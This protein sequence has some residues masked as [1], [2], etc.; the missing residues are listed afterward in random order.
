M[1]YLKVIP[2]VI[3]ILFLNALLASEKRELNVLLITA[4]TLR[5]DRVSFHV[6]D[7]VKTPHLDNLAEGSLVFTR[8]F[9]H[10]PVT[11][12]SHVNIITGTTPLYHGISDNPGFVLEERF[13]T[14]A[15]HL[16]R[17]KYK[18]GAFIA[19]FPLDSRFGLDQG[20]DH[21]DDNYG[22]QN[23]YQMF[24][25]ER[26]ADEVVDPALTWIK[27]QDGKWFCW[28]H[29]FDPHKFYSPPPPYDDLYKDDPYSG[30]VAFMDSQVGALLGGLKKKGLL[31]NTVVV[32]TSDHGEGL[33]DKGELTHSYFA[34]NTTI[35]VPLFI[36]IPGTDARII[37]ENVC[38]V[39]IFPT[40]CDVLGLKIPSHI[41][42]ESLLPISEGKK[43]IRK[44]IYFE[45][46]TPY[47]T[48]GWAPLT[49]FIKEDIKYI[50]LPIKEVYSLKEDMN[51]DHNL[52][53]NYDV[54]SLE[55]ELSGLKE[56]LRGKGVK[57]NLDREDQEVLNKLRTLGYIAAGTATKQ[58]V[59]TE[60]D[61]LKVL[62]PFHNKMMRS[63]EKFRSGKVKEAEADLLNV[64]E[65]MPSLI[66]AFSRLANLYYSTDRKDQAIQI[67]RRALEENPDNLHITSRLGLM[68]SEV[69]EYEEAIR[70]LHICIKKEGR[71]PD[72]FNYIGVAYQKS[73]KFY[74]ALDYYQKALELDRSNAVVYN[75]IGSVYLIHF[76]KTRDMKYYRSALENFNSA[77]TFNPFL[78]AA[79]NG[80]DA[81]E[82]FRKK[83]NKI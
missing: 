82:K 1:K 7:F 44:K 78:K 23:F 45:S 5:F 36:K 54:S 58:K 46:L 15:E 27:E 13:L 59:Y 67:L 64:V 38:H 24:Y 68:L 11:L 77:L 17:K 33:G 8:A 26:P 39:D 76:M 70:L 3:L 2:V 56:S 80:I 28:I 37:E 75:N 66:P 18:T 14:L 25:A 61:D 52:A 32:F 65:N 73:G 31:Q 63:V 10:N 62:K 51:E 6:Q 29:L 72:F 4:D 83:I 16:K 74:L 41:Q 21:Y 43:R 40:V 12:P 30:E 57:Q 71:N 35:H 48:T 50:D 20:F 81:A 53:E 60:K 19:S 34:Y 47:L 69:Q 55:R 49:G 42:G 79:K 9:A 22:V